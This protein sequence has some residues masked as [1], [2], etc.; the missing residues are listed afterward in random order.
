MTPK[1]QMAFGGGPPITH[2]PPAM[3]AMFQPG[4]PL[5]FKDKLR[6]RKCPPYSG[7]AQWMDKFE[8]EPP[9]ERLIEE[10][11]RDRRLAKKVAT[12]AVNELKLAEAKA[13][14]DPHAPRAEVA[15][16]T[17]TDAYKTLFVG[18]L[19]YETTES[20]L[21]REFEQFGSIKAL[22]LVTDTG[23]HNNNGHP[24][25]RGYAFIEFEKESDMRGAYKR[26]DGRRI[27]GRRIIVDV[28]RGRTVRN[29]KPRRLGGG[30]GGLSR[31]RPAQPTKPVQQP[32]SVAHRP[33]PRPPPAHRYAD[34]RN[35][36][37]RPERER[38]RDRDRERDRRY[39]DR[40]DRDRSRRKDRSRSRSRERSR[41]Y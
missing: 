30:L 2:L 24:K 13:A 23:P 22:R 17:T 28:E 8:T 3:K 38:D 40:D 15:D 41:R 5:P 37:A 4:P 18:R 39:R 21:H 29:W 12:V 6:K 26:A 9:P 16:K 7:L 35:P 32:P 34:Y 20:K 31:K 27:D 25:P 36:G 14:W 33:P 19:S 11:P 10:T 1:G